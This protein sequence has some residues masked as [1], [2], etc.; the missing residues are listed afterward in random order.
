MDLGSENITFSLKNGEIL[1][2]KPLGSSFS[3]QVR[4]FQNKMLLGFISDFKSRLPRHGGTHLATAALPWR[5][6]SR[7]SGLHGTRLEKKKKRR[8]G[9]EEEKRRSTS[10]RQDHRGFSSGVIPTKIQVPRISILH[11]VDSTEHSRVCDEPHCIPEDS[12]ILC[13]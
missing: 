13:T 11:V 12:I 10:F 9:E 7:L 1:S 3:S 6:K 8:R 2:R 5:Q 4:K